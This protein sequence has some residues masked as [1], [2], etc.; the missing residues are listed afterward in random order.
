MA[1]MGGRPERSPIKV[2]YTDYENYEISYDCKEF[3]GMKTEYFGVS[4]RT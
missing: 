3:A 4:S 2:F 1:T